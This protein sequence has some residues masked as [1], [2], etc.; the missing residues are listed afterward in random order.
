[1]W[2]IGSA[3]Y[4][5]GL[6]WQTAAGVTATRTSTGDDYDTFFDPNGTVIVSGTTGGISIHSW[7][8]G[9]RA[10]IGRAG[11]VTITAGYR[12]RVDI[13]DFQLGHK[14]V[15]R[16]G[17]VVQTFDTTAPEHTSSQLHEV[18]FGETWSHGLGSSGW[19]ASIDAEIAPAAI[20]RLLVQ[21]PEKYPGQDLVFYATAAAGAA[22]VTLT[23]SH[24]SVGVDLLH[25]WSYS[26]TASLARDAV[27]LRVS[28]GRP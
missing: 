15:A 4:T 22:H 21:L 24:V 28:F 13:S 18:F 8:A 20:G 12:L 11:L 17:V 23:R 16:N 5:A 19:R 6:K 25:T 7:R 10:E 9:Q 14:T 27:A 26:S 1:V 2:L 3:R